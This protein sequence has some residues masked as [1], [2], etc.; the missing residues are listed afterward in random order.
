MD[1]TNLNE[2][3]E[4]AKN[5]LMMNIMETEFSP[6]IVSHPFT[7]C[8]I[9]FCQEGEDFAQFD[10]TKNRKNLIKWQKQVKKQIDESHSVYDIYFM[11][12]PSYKM[13]YFSCIA[14]HLSSEDFA[15]LLGSVWVGSEY[16]NADVNVPKKQMLEYFKFA[17]KSKLMTEEEME[18]FKDLDDEIV[19]YRGLSSNNKKNIKALSWTT[20]FGKA[21]WFAERWGENEGVVYSAN[22]DKKDVYAYFDRKNEDEVVVDYNKLRNIKVTTKP[23]PKIKSNSQ[24]ME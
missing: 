24:S 21:K 14:Q 1:K 16:A 15:S 8:G 23:L 17:D 20:S 18:T 12:N 3:K 2:V 4:I 5:L 13:L 9:V 7:N 6:M 19:I 10:I 22:I 11:I